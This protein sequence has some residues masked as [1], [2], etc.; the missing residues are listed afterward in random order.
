[1][2]GVERSRLGRW[3]GEGKR[4]VKK[5]LKT[6]IAL[7]EREL[8][9]ADSDLD[10]AVRCSPVRR[11]QD[12]LLHGMP[13][14]GTVLSHPLLADMPE[15]GLLSRREMATVAGVAPLSRDS[16][17]RRGRRFVEGGRGPP[18][19]VRNLFCNTV[20]LATL[21]EKDDSIRGYPQSVYQ[22]AGLLCYLSARLF[23]A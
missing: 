17:T 9:I 5:R 8:R 13:G 1:M 15:L 21:D 18:R 6:H 10:G 7:L 14:V 20:L 4:P 2:M 3:F 11:D 23:E 16:G 19:G 12:D 22:V